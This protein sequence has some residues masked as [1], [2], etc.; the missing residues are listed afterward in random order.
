M[1]MQ[2]EIIKIL[3]DGK[4]HSGAALG[5]RLGVSRAA[6]WKRLKSI[7]LEGLEVKKKR[8]VGY[9]LADKLELLSVNSI[10]QDLTAETS[11]AIQ[12]IV[13]LGTIDSTN[14]FVKR[15]SE[16]CGATR[17]IALAER[18]TAGRGRHGKRW[19]GSFAGG[20]NMSIIWEFESGAASLEGISLAVGVAARRALTQMGIGGVKLKWPNDVFLSGKKLGGILLEVLGDPSGPC[21]VIIGVGINYFI[22]DA[23]R[24]NIDQPLTDIV[25]ETPNHVSRNALCASL[26][27]ELIKLLKSYESSG[28]MPYRDE[29]QLSDITYGRECT[30]QAGK[31]AITGTAIGIDVNGAIILRTEIG[32]EFRF[33]G[34]NLSLR[35]AK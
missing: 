33:L 30:I 13:L 35:L 20:I 15:F 2:D 18:Q 25:S 5:E 14:T 23:V 10:K 31:E 27:S 16:E 21:S 12:H 11:A 24:K 1:D 17:I 29:W 28:F 6:I 9:K 26:I 19:L 4:Y 8:G 32:K 7:E 3:C 34:G 22:S